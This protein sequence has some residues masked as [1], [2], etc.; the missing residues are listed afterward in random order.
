MKAKEQY[1]FLTIIPGVLLLVLIYQ[2]YGVFEVSEQRDIGMGTGILG[3]FVLILS[4]AALWLNER[5]QSSLC[6][7]AFYTAG[8]LIA[9]SAA[10]FTLVVLCL[11]L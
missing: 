8:H 2:R 9:L 6:S 3:V 7:Y 4:G 11:G 1:K 5:R 10:A